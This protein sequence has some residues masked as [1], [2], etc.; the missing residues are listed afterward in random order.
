MASQL[1]T[2]DSVFHSAASPLSL[3]A[4][5]YG[6]W[7][8]VTWS[9]ADPRKLKMLRLMKSTCG[10]M[11]GMSYEISMSLG[12]VATE[13]DKIFDAVSFVRNACRSLT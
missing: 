6:E 3:A 2:M 4:L 9:A 5:R 7:K 10:K 11:P 1:S 8:P 12:F 13:I